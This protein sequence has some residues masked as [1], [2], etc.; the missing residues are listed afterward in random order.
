MVSDNNICSL[1]IS[2]KL[3]HNVH[4]F[5]DVMLL[6]DCIWSVVQIHMHPQYGIDSIYGSGHKGAAVLLPGFAI[7]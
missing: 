3:G 6:F 2:E 7:I 1:A 4:I 5:P